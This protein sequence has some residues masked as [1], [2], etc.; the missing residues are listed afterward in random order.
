MMIPVAAAL[1]T[2]TKLLQVHL[3][4]QPAASFLPS[5]LHPITALLKPSSCK[6]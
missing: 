4:Q 3:L 2:V 1:G 5:F 6:L